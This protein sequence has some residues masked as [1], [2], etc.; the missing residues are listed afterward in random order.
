MVKPTFCG[1]ARKVGNV[2]RGDIGSVFGRHPI[3]RVI[4]AI[5]QMAEVAIPHRVFAA[6]LTM[7]NGLRGPPHPTVS[8]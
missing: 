6:I 5:F 8:A 1:Q 4:Y 3:N 7:I 2:P